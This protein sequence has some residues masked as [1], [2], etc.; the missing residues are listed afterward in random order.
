[1]TRLFLC[2][3]INAERQLFASHHLYDAAISLNFINYT[4]NS[5]KHS[6]IAIERCYTL[7]HRITPQ[8]QFLLPVRNLLKKIYFTYL[9][10]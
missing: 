3:H 6:I 1:M 5:K 10:A 7:Y 2:S 9:I 4:V 8:Q